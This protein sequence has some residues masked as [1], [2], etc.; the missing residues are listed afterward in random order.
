MWQVL[1]MSWRRDRVAACLQLLQRSLTV[2]CFADRL[3]DSQETL[4]DGCKKIDGIVDSFE[5]VGLRDRSMVWNTDLV[6]VRALTAHSPERA[7]G[8]HPPRGHSRS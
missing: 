1:P 2:L 3:E 7:C 6:E 4:E 8:S 5:D